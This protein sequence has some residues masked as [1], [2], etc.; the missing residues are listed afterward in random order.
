[1]MSEPF[2]NASATPSAERPGPAGEA[3]DADAA[4][5]AEARV[6]VAPVLFRRRAGRVVGEEDVMHRLTCAGAELDRAHPP[7]FGELR[8]DDEIAVDVGA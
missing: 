2:G 1:M 4:H 8:G 3:A 6:T 5:A 7:V